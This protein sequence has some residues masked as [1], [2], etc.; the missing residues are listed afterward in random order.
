[1]WS[2]YTLYA[3]TSLKLHF[4]IHST[5]IELFSAFDDHRHTTLSM[6]FGLEK[7]LGWFESKHTQKIF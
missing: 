4:G 6:H 1:M 5:I 7:F 3:S 2:K